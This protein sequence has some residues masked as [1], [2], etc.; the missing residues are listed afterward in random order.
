VELEQHRGRGHLRTGVAGGDERV[1][2][3]LG[4]Q[5]ETDDHRAVRLAAHGR[6][7]LVGHFDDVRRLD[8]LNA[9][10]ERGSGREITDT[11]C[12][13]ARTNDVDGTDELKRVLDRQLENGMERSGYRRIR[14]EIS[15]HRVQRDPRQG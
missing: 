13:Y 1:R 12:G 14:G 11:Q 6:R 2:S 3:P 10:R 4:L 5:L 15:P 8:E 7:R 9:A